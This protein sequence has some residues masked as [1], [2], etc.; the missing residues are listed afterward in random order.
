MVADIARRCRRPMALDA[1]KGVLGTMSDR[2][3]AEAVATLRKDG[4]VVFDTK[5]SAGMCAE[6][7]RF[8]ETTPAEPEAEAG[9][10]REPV[11]YDASAPLSRR[12]TFSEQGVGPQPS[13]QRL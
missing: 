8:A 12:D 3:L 10:R 6:L 11:M 4:F 5:L 7:R 1:D 2:R 13:V 9:E